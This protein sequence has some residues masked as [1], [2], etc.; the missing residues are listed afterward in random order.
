MAQ[1]SCIVTAVAQVQSLAQQLLLHIKA[2][3]H[4]LKKKIGQSGI[5][6]TQE[7]F[8][9]FCNFFV[10]LKLFETEKFM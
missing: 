10:S 9:L 2:P 5:K 3:H 4:H 1:W 6:G 7:F 8:A